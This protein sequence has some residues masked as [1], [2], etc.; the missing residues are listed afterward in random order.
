M[1]KESHEKFSQNFNKKN[2]E[3]VTEL[4]EKPMVDKFGMFLDESGNGENIIP[5]EE[6]RKICAKSLLR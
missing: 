3:N 5:T 1:Q 4:I 2:I 6:S